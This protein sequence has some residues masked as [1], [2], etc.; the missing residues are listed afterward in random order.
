MTKPQRRIAFRRIAD[1]AA[2][3]TEII[4]FR[5][6]PDGKREGH[7]WSAINPTRGRKLQTIFDRIVWR[8]NAG[9]PRAKAE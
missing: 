7:E 1:A 8:P 3:R 2:A 5:W 9:E 4:V 6:L